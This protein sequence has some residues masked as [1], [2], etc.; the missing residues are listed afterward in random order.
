MPD[1][2]I[3]HKSLSKLYQRPYRFL[4]EG[5]ATDAECSTAFLRAF[6]RDLQ[7]VG[8]AVAQAALVAGDALSHARAMPGGFDTVSANHAV[9]DALRAVRCPSAHQEGLRDAARDVAQGLRYGSGGGTDDLGAEVYRRFA[10]RRAESQFEARVPL[11]DAHHNG[12]SPVDIEGR[13]RAMAPE[14]GRAVFAFARKVTTGGSV[15]DFRLPPQ[16]RQP[17]SLEENLL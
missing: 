10:L 4:C 13:I 15:N 11:T 3:I 17:V 9:D 16:R 6:K 1:G 12:A 14:I 8:D 5:K 7:K 2:D